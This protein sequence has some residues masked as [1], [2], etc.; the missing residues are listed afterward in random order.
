MDAVTGKNAPG[1]SLVLVH[2]FAG[3]I[4]LLAAVLL[5]TLFPEMLSGHYFS[6][7][8]LAV[9]HLLVLGWITMIIFGALYQL[10]PVIFEVKL[11]SERLGYA[12]FG[13]LL[14]GAVLLGYSFWNFELGLLINVAGSAVVSA[15]ILFAILICATAIRSAKRGIERDFI[16]TAL[17][18]LL[19]TVVAG[20]LLAINLAHPF[21]E[22]SHVQLLKLHAHAGM[23]GWIFQLIMGVGSKLLPMFMISGNLSKGKLN[24][25]YYFLNGG[26]IS[27]IV[28]LYIG[29]STGVMLSAIVAF[30]GVI[31]FLAFIA[32][33]YRNR[34]RK[35][36]DVMMK[37][38]LLSFI[39]LI[40]PV[41]V[42][43]TLFYNN[44][45]EDHGTPTLSV[46]YGVAI[47]LGFITQLIMGQTLKTLPFIVWL[48]VYRSRVGKEKTPL[49]KDLY[50]ERLAILQ[51]W[52]YA[53]GFA[54]L[55]FGTI[56]ANDFIIRIGALTLILAVWIYNF[57]VLK[58]IL[59][60]P[61]SDGT[62]RI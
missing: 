49:P 58:V 57:N 34:I 9:T 20:L 7:K 52:V 41:V 61:E 44:P 10:V 31:F 18:W 17:I 11:F 51:T 3:G 42:L 50:S 59:H 47:I 14:S 55:M 40:V 53:S 26:L 4:C 13:F 37:Q 35:K 43:V 16:M 28:C 24:W 15:V 29:W 22:V 33:A 48:S 27:G 45:M 1:A 60:K 6:P 8:L 30:I 38:S 5:L 23:I 62:A 46:G 12:A 21:L 36:L 25:A 2:F 19:F 56:I 39:T 54:I 32:L